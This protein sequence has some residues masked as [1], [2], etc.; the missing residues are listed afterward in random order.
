MWMWFCQPVI[1]HAINAN[2]SLR[3]IDFIC[4]H[5]KGKSWTVL[6]PTTF[7]LSSLTLLSLFQNTLQSSSFLCQKDFFDSGFSR[8][9]PDKPHWFPVTAST[10][11]L[12]NFSSSSQ[13]N[14]AF[15]YLSSK[16]ELFLWFYISSGGLMSIYPYWHW[17]LS[18]KGAHKMKEMVD[19]G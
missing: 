13:F 4:Y 17:F 3:L 9:C 14:T 1:D 2:S 11:S 15:K 6:P 5:V 8:T 12:E 10:V 18:G 19:D 7:V 16:M